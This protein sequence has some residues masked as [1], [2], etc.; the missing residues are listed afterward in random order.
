MKTAS[1]NGF[2]VKVRPVTPL[3][4]LAPRLALIAVT[5]LLVVFGLIMVYS[6]S[7]IVGLSDYGDSAYF[8]KKQ[9]MILGLGLVAL[10]ICAAVPYRFWAG[11]FS[12]GAWLVLVALLIA[13][14]VMG[15]GEL[16]ATRWI[17]IA[18]FNLQP[19][20]FAKIALVLV[21]AQIAVHI[22]DQGTSPQLAG[23]AIAA[24]A[25]PVLL[26]FLQPD[27][28]TLAIAMVGVGVVLWFGEFPRS[29]ILALLGALVVV[30]LIAMTS[31]FRADRIDS[32]QDP[33]ADPLGTGY[34]IRNSLFALSD[35]GLFGTGLGMS[36]QKFLYLPMAQNDFIFAIIGEELG[37]LGAL[38]VVLLFVA[39][40]WASLQVARH[41]PDVA[42]RSIAAAAGTLIGVQ[43]FLNIFCVI[44]IIPVTGKPLPFISDGGTSLISSLML[45]GLI[46]SV[47]FNSA[48]PD[49]ATARRDGFIIFDG[50]RTGPSKPTPGKPRAPKRG[51]QRAPQPAA[52]RAPA[53]NRPPAPATARLSMPRTSPRISAPISKPAPAPS[54]IARSDSKVV[55]LHRNAVTRERSARQQHTQNQKR[56]SS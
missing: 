27:Y 23:A 45:V 6:A 38:A 28:G 16:G 40:I 33:E 3:N 36:R 46:L 44:G 24:L 32:W 4:I 7:S 26:L 56:R 48:Q 35:G 21:G 52:V 41:A 43:A 11:L 1:N 34:Q 29:W 14:L 5:V 19:G 49:A 30:S 47:S 17:D 50:G 10:V 37:L 39:F 25:V 53:R 15:N 22:K 8:F 54:R 12:A 18:G 20:E 51:P 42:G 9:L 2:L 13:I 31:Q 55:A